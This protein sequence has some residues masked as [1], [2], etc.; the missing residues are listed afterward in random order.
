MSERVS[1]HAV[2]RFLERQY[3]FDIEELRRKIEALCRPA[4]RAGCLSLV[5]E[6]LRYEFSNDRRVVVTVVP[7][8][9]L[10]SET[11]KRKLGHG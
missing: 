11:K 3:G 4:M 8:K 9:G 7:G 6:G 2:L 10:A 1:D 5:S